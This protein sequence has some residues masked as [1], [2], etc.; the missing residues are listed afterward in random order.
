VRLASLS[1]SSSFRARPRGASRMAQ[2]HEA[3]RWQ[4]TSWPLGRPLRLPVQVVVAAPT[5]LRDLGMLQKLDREIPRH[6]VLLMPEARSLSRCGDRASWLA[7]SQARGFRY[8]PPVADRTLG[9]PARRVNAG[10]G[11]PPPWSAYHTPRRNQR[12][13]RLFYRFLGRATSCPGRSFL[14]PGPDARSGPPTVGKSWSHICNPLE[15]HSDL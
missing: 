4:P 3:T 15:L 10:D 14:R 5:D 9:Q 7:S 6:K 11:G 2:R 12:P 1:P 13:A 8:G